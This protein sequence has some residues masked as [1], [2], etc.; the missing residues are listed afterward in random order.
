[1]R[2]THRTPYDMCNCS[3]K[4]CKWKVPTALITKGIASGSL[5]ENCVEQI[6]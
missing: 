3:S 5:R 2:Y 6:V 1:M 4:A